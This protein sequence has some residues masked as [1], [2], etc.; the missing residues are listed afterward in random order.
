MAE[1]RRA[2]A[3]LALAACCACTA[4]GADRSPDA[5]AARAAKR[6]AVIAAGPAD[7]TAKLSR[8]TPGDTLLLAPGLYDDPG[9]APGLSIRNLHGTAAAPIV[10]TGPASGPRPVLVGRAGYN[11]VR[12]AD[13]S[14]IV[15]RNFDI[16]GRDLGG[17]GIKAQ[18]PTQ[19]ITIENQT[20]RG[21]G[22]DQSVVGI[23]TVG[24]PAAHWTIRGNT[25]VA[26]GTGMYLGHSDGHHPFVAG[27]I[28]GNVIRDTIG[29]NVQVKHQVPWA[30][31]EG[32]PTGRTVTVIRHNVFSK[33]RNSST[34]PS[35]R[36][37]LLVG[38]VPPSGPGSDNGYAIYGNYFHRNPSEALFQGEGNVAL[39][40]NVFFNDEGPAIHVQRHNGKVRRI[41]VIGNTVVASGTGIS[42]SDG[43]PGYTQRVAMNAV[44]SPAPVVGAS[45]ADNLADEFANASRHLEQPVAAAGRLDLR[46]RNGAMRRNAGPVEGIAGL[47]DGDR[48][49]E[50]RP[51]RWSVYGA[52]DEAGG[53]AGAP[54]APS[55]TP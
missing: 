2:W 19:H 13:A 26:A 32:L 27:L 16:D 3:A 54:A 51:R 37:N 10:V 30:T 21:V 41:D 50:S 40:A 9:Q 17:D 46:P 5:P 18:G 28:E 33:A 43:E 36:P 31:L 14:H 20:I 29:Y 6:G 34:G 47:V 53:T 25:I 38:D 22:P 15:L 24:G 23:S 49:Y 52:Y 7:Y 48:D 11:T 8:L 42:I 4:I 12:L 35:A 55:R 1:P 45:S 39:Y 44:F